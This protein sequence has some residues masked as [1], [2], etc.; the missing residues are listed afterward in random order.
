MQRAEQNGLT[1]NGKRPHSALPWFLLFLL[2]FSILFG[3]LF[4]RWHQRLASIKRNPHLRRAWIEHTMWATPSQ[5]G[6]KL[7]VI[8]ST[9]QGFG[10]EQP[11]E[12]TYPYLLE[13]QLHEKLDQPVRVLNWSVAGGQ[14]LDYILTGAAAHRLD[15]DLVLLC[16]VPRNFGGGQL[17][18]N[19]V[20]REFPPRPSD[21]HLLAGYS[22]VRRHVPTWL[23]RRLFRPSDALE[24][25][26][27]RIWRP[28]R[29]REIPSAWLVRFSVFR[30]FE[31]RRHADWF[32]REGLTTGQRNQKR[33]LRA[34]PTPRIDWRLVDTYLETI[35]ALKD[36]SV[37]VSMPLR[38]TGPK[39]D[40]FDE[41]IRKRFE[42]AGARMWDLSESLP[43]E[44][45]LTQSHLDALGHETMADLL[46]DLIA[47]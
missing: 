38:V 22:D 24:I 17:V 29:Y 23:L 36:K 34:K 25:A 7:I 41:E 8:L 44:V 33:D 20:T 30:F 18:Q 43:D 13:S 14:A 3:H 27:A 16:A 42:A 39:E 45:F 1:A 12:K 10:F 19:P 35:D 15:P 2:L 32:R 5:P 28:W 11:D 46:T 4:D 37:Y 31:K 9:S 26:L 47:P 21:T 6:E 40:A